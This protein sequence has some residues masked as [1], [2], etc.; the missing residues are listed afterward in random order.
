MQPGMLGDL[1]PRMYSDDA[2]ILPFT[3]AI[4]GG[5]VSVTR[6]CCHQGWVTLCPFLW[7]VTWVWLDITPYPVPGCIP[8]LPWCPVDRWASP[9]PSPAACTAGAKHVLSQRHPMVIAAVLCSFQMVP[10]DRR[11]A[12]AIVLV[13]WV[14]AIASSLIDNIP[15][16]ATMVSR[17][18]SLTRGPRVS[19]DTTGLAPSPRGSEAVP[20]LR[21]QVTG[22][23]WPSPGSRLGAEGSKFE[24]S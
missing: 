24:V 19:P 20:W 6:V 11:L 22:Q 10:E 12:A 1:P 18:C 21:A 7:L 8:G 2:S 14:S 5:Q 3:L 9:A 23:M 16:T 4:P 15:F 17:T 13:L